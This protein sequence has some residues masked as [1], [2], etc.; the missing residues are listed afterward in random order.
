MFVLGACKTC[1]GAGWI[2]LTDLTERRGCYHER[3]GERDLVHRVGFASVVQRYGMAPRASIDWQWPCP[4]TVTLF[5]CVLRRTYFDSWRA[6][7]PCR[8]PRLYRGDSKPPNYPS[9]GGG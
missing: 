5:V 3:E 2:I 9:F 1:F 7:A 8:S 4:Q 6:V